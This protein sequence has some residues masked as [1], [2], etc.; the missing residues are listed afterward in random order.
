ME[1]GMDAGMDA[2]MDVRMDA[3]MWGWMGVGTGWMWVSA[4]AHPLPMGSLSLIQCQASVQPQ[5]E[6][7]AGLMSDAWGR[8]G[9]E[10][11]ELL[12]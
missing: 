5:G 4:P 2:V 9:K 8:E 3:G 6:L 7:G 1:V 11:T 12:R 10:G